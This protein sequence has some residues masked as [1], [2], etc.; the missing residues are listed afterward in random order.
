MV[1]STSTLSF[2]LLYPTHDPP[3]AASP[4]P[5]FRASPPSYLVVPPLRRTNVTPHDN[6]H[7]PSSPLSSQN[8]A[9]K[10]PRAPI[11][12]SFPAPSS[13]T[14]SPYTQRNS[15]SFLAL[16]SGHQF[17][18]TGPF[19]NPDSLGI[20]EFSLDI[21]PRGIQPST[22]SALLFGSPQPQDASSLSATFPPGKRSTPLGSER[23][24]PVRL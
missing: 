9:V 20:P 1:S 24:D 6:S 7:P 5:S 3:A 21:P 2:V 18:P 8:V 14:A 22:Q 19:G 11:G 12:L 4:P 17:L 10:D 13:A 16:L 15:R 23:H